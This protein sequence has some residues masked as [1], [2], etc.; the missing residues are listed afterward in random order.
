MANEQSHQ[1][2]HILP[3]IIN[4][5]MIARGLFLFILNILL[6][7]GVRHHVRES[8]VHQINDNSFDKR[9]IHTII[10]INSC[11]LLT[12]V[13]PIIYAFHLFRKLKS[14]STRF[15]LDDNDLAWGNTVAVLAQSYS[16]INA[17]IY[18]TR[19]R[20][21]KLFYST[22]LRTCFM[23]NRADKDDMSGNTEESAI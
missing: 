18:M 8:S 13:L 1:Y 19:S 17:V 12:Q 7:V 9:V 5:M 10:I 22:A 15:V 3:A 20:K 6:A 11:L 4:S 2:G 16:F 23:R 21:I 14:N